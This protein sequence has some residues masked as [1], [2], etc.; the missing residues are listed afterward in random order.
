L[1]VLLIISFSPELPLN[2]FLLREQPADFRVLSDGINL[3][4]YQD[5]NQADKAADECEKRHSAIL[6]STI[7]SMTAAM[8]IEPS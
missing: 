7:S 6:P 5:Q 1:R 3:K 2:P 4:P 8:R